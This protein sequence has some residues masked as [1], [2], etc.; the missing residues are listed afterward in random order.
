MGRLARLVIPGIPHHVTQRGN[1]RDMTFFGDEDY[2]V[3]RAMLAE[4]AGRAG[5]RSGLIA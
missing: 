3:Y 2:A 5:A 4:A 1:R